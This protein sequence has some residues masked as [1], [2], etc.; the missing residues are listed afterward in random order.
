MGYEWVRNIPFF[1]KLFQ[2]ITGEK[3]QFDVLAEETEVCLTVKLIL[4]TKKALIQYSV[5]G[6][7]KFLDSIKNP[8]NTKTLSE[9]KVSPTSVDNVMAAFRIA[10]V[11]TL[12]QRSANIVT[13]L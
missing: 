4:L 12:W 5:C 11:V 8:A 2:F 10:V 3:L 13:A 6:R 9:M 1:R 7:S